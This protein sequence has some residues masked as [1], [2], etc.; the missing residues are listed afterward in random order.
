MDV[1]IVQLDVS[2]Q[3]IRQERFNQV[4]SILQNLQDSEKHP[5]LILLPEIWGT[6]FFNFHDYATHSEEAQGETYSFL[7]PW[8]K[9][10]NC[11]ILGGSIVEQ[12]DNNLYNSALMIDPNG[13]LVGTYRKIHLFGYQS[14]ESRLLSRGTTP[15]VLKTEL[16]TVGIT[17]CYDL[18]F[19]ELYRAMAN[20][21]AEIFLV[22]SAWPLARL[23][24]W[25]L[26]N[27]V[28]ALENQC[29]LIS[30]NCAGKI[31]EQTFAGNSM[32]VDPWGTVLYTAGEEACVLRGK[33]DTGK[34]AEIRNSF[35]AFSD[36]VL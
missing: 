17:T 5:D 1:A 16:G 33:V 3:Q 21:G 10:M 12:C 26:F 4:R 36:R 25:T 20:A 8:A 13:E 7:A 23:E 2:D 6:G 29:Y 28:R 32:I 27:R 9:K 14:E 22:V 11:H 30:C 24:H 19:P 31:K 35:P 18:R 34:V 15:T